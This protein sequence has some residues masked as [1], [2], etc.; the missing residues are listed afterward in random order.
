MKYPISSILANSS[1]SG[2]T[3]RQKQRNFPFVKSE[4]NTP[5]SLPRNPVLKDGTSLTEG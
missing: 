1:N 3:E 2:E 5:L 4:G